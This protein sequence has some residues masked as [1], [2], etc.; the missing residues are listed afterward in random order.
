MSHRRIEEAEGHGLSSINRAPG[1]GKG[2]PEKNVPI[3]DG[4]FTHATIYFKKNWTIYYSLLENYKKL[5]FI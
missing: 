4:P 2:E 5:Y 1:Q 3:D